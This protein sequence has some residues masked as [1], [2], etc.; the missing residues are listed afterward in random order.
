MEK[1][2]ESSLP[3]KTVVEALDLRHYVLQ[4]FE[5]ALN[6]PNAEDKMSLMNYVIVG[7][8]PTGV[9]LAGALGEL[10]KHVLPCDYPD[11]DFK[12][13]HI[14]LIES[15]P[16]VLASFD[17]KS[18]HGALKYLKEL[19]VIVRTDTQV[20]DYDGRNVVISKD[21]QL[22]ASTLIWTAGVIGKNIPGL[23]AE[24]VNRGGRIEVD[25]FC[26][27]KGYSNI[28]AIGDVAAMYVDEF[29]KGHPMVA[30][31]AIQQGELV[32]KNLIR[33]KQGKDLVSFKYKD[34]GSMA[35]VGRNRAVVE[36][37]KYRTQGAFAWFMW[38]FVHLFALIGFRNRIVVF[39]NWLWSYFNYDRGMR[40]I[41]RPYKKKT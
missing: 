30:Q 6:T 25:T 19:D 31:V 32:G 22:K 11:L 5:K 41:I 13:M 15:A 38:M 8:G 14:H 2:K 4:N 27:V 17:E 18:S 39:I 36:I 1:L 34:K 3:M 23:K 9:E 35:T 12:M 28:F 16:R 37:G 10:K 29:P 21:P 40:L 7:G 20:K 33:Q 26:R 24:V